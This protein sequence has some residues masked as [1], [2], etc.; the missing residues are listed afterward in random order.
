LGL[1]KTHQR[2]L[3]RDCDLNGGGGAALP[4]VAAQFRQLV[5]R[6]R[7]SAMR[8]ADVV[9]CRELGKSKSPWRRQ[10]RLRPGQARKEAEGFEA[11]DASIDC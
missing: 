10:N 11:S 2:P 3:E 7:I 6:L 5:S 9:G 8:P 4:G 1:I